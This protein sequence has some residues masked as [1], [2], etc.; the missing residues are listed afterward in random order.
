MERA[1]ADILMAELGDRL[2]VPAMALDADGM[3][4]LSIDG[5]AVV[6]GVRYDQQS[7]AIDLRAGL[8]DM[9]P[10]PAR[11]GRAL[12]ANF[13]WQLTGGAILALDAATGRL[14]LR[15]RCSGADLDSGRLNEALED[16]VADAVAWS[17]ALRDLPEDGP[18]AL[19]PA[20]PPKLPFGSLRA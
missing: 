5:D 15:R 11:L 18:S 16:L 6:V 12:S 4:L 2:G 7:G 19:A 1:Q 9:V 13:S 8:D 20:D 17:K 14:E 3:A 10:S